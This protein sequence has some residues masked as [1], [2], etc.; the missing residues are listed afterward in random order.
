[1]GY[2]AHF[3]TEKKVQYDGGVFN[4]HCE[5]LANF[6]S[7][8]CENAYISDDKEQWEIPVDDFK[9]MLTNLEEKFEPTEEVVG[10]YTVEECLTIFKHWLN[11]TEEHREN[12]TY[13]YYIYIEWF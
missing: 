1:M 12:Y 10:D 3:L 8:E 4:L 2:R 5:E 7:S 6:I 9:K 13:P 11:W